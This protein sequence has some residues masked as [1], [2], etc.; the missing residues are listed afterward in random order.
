MPQADGPFKILEKVNDNA[1]LELPL[2]FGISPTF[3]IVD[4]TAYM[5]EEDEPESRT[6]PLQ[7]GEGDEDMTPMHMVK[8]PPIVI[9]GPITRARVQQLHLHL[10]SFL[11]THAYSCE[12]GMLSNDIINYIILRNFGNDHEGLG[13]QQGQGGKHGGRPSQD[14][15]LIQLRFDYLGHQEQGSLK[16]SPRPQTHSNF[17]DP[18]MPGNITREPF[19]WN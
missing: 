9:Q 14:G 16:S 10:S 18:H 3:N 2:D 19:Q 6:T 15:G 12:D 11:S 1:K 8:T 17:N 4:L 7:D 5:G 13:Y